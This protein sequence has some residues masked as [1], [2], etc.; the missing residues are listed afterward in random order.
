M[1]KSES[2]VV[3][4][5]IKSVGRSIKAD[6]IDSVLPMIAKK[7]RTTY[8]KLPSSQQ[9]GTSIQ[10]LINDGKTHLLS[11]IKQFDPRKWVKFSTWAFVVLD[12]FYVDMIRSAYA[13]SHRA[14][15]ISET[16]HVMVGRDQ[17]P[18]S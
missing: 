11:V 7:A 14:R 10:D 2:S 16:S 5:R 4:D 9:L 3:V 6:R 1:R 13:L 15:V 8:N 12:N 18:Q 17:E